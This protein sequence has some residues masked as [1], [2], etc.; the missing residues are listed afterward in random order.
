MSGCLVPCRVADITRGVL[1]VSGTEFALVLSRSV[2]FT[3]FYSILQLQ[4]WAEIDV[5]IYLTVIQ[6]LWDAGESGG[7]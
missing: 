1:G 2:D 6:Q 4:L 3:E 7:L 5:R